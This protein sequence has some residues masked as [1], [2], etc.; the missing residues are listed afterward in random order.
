MAKEI[1]LISGIDCIR[2]PT[3][4]SGEGN[5]IQIY[6]DNIPY[7]RA[8]QESHCKLL[9]NFLREVEI[10]DFDKIEANRSCFTR[11]FIAEKDEQLYKVVGAGTISEATIIPENVRELSGR[12]YIAI[13][14]YS[15][16]YNLYPV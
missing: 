16:D 11:A 9:E 14:G 6:F 12:G 4:N 13:R 2:N 5:F 8:G 7:F 10:E 1:P 15:E 3:I